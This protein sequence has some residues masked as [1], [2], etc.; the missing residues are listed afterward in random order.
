MTSGTVFI[1]TEPENF[2]YYRTIP[3]W[4]QKVEFHPF[5]AP[6]HVIQQ[7]GADLLLL[8][9]GRD[10]SKGLAL[11]QEIKTLRPEI[12]V[13]F[14]TETQSEETALQAFRQGARDY[15]R[16]PLDLFK[17]KEVIENLLKIK[18][19]SSEKRTHQGSVGTEGGAEKVLVLS[20]DTPANLL[21]SLHYIK[22][23]FSDQLTIE[24]LAAQAGISKFHFCRKFKKHTGMSPMNF[25]TLM[26]IEKA[27]GLLGRNIPVSAVAYKVGFNDL[28]NF[29]RSFKKVTGQTPSTYKKIDSLP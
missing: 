1:I 26:R 9:C 11:L 16:K 13:L 29:I 20:D 21:R 27:K 28:G 22:T 19:R 10:D 25:V 12:M 7:G 24:H 14:V 8:D 23:N 3:L 18:G 6:L 4:E 5:A 17:L 15:F 2:A